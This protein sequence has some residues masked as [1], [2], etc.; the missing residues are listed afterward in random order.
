M[1]YLE[2]HVG[3]FLAPDSAGGKFMRSEATGIDLAIKGLA[4]ATQDDQDLLERGMAI[5]DGLYT[6]L[7]RK[8]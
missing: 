2:L 4:E 8:I 6:V 3:S 1:T 7:K 5:F